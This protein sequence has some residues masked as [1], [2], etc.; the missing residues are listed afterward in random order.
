MCDQYGNYL[1]LGTD[2]KTYYLDSEYAHNLQD[3]TARMKTLMFKG[4]VLMT[5]C[6]QPQYFVCIFRKILVGRITGRLYMEVRKVG[7]VT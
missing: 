1:A 4:Y 2:S 5:F 7:V 3:L 6:A